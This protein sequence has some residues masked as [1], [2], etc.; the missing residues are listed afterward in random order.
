M[1]GPHDKSPMRKRLLVPILAVVVPL[2]LAAAVF[3]PATAG[4]SGQTPS[5]PASSSVTDFITFYGYPDNSPPSASIDHPCIHQTAGGTGTYADPVTFAEPTDLNG[6]WCQKIYI[7]SLKKYFI[8]EDQC[9][10]CGGVNSGHV[11][12]WMGGDASSMSD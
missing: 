9:D 5:C 2:A 3:L 8:H 6:P 7:P 11:D 1:P 4:A 12:L 10:P